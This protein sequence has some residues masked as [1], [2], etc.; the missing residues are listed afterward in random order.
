MGDDR[1][2]VRACEMGVE[3]LPR[4]QALD[5]RKAP[6]IVHSLMERVEDAFGFAMRGLDERRE[7]LGERGFLARG[8]L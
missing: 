2:D 6:R 5:E 8:E 1:L 7:R 3:H 4:L